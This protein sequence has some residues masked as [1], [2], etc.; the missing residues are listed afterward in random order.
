MIKLM[1]TTLFIVLGLSVAIPQS[2]SAQDECGKA[3]RSFLGI[4]SWDRGLGDCENIGINDL[5]KDDK[6]NP[7]LVV[8]FNIMEAIIRIA[9]MVAIAFLI[10][11]GFKYVLSEGN[12][13]K[14]AE[15]QSTAINAL[16]GMVI[17]VLGVAAIRAALKVFG[18]DF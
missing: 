7:I 13:Q 9:G 4:P 6:A 18:V 3:G 10:V 8:T 17:A 2:V 1:I 11:A 14:A 16:I 12:P 5:V 15:A